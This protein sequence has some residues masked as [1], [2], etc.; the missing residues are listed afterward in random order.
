MLKI[1]M[2]GMTMQ[3]HTRL[4]AAV[5]TLCLALPA[6]AQSALDFIRHDRNISASNY[7]T[8]PDNL[9][10]QL[11]PPPA[12][13]RPFYISHY[14]RHGSRYMSNRKGYDIPYNMLC[15]ADSMHILTPLGRQVKQ[16][17]Y[18]IIADSE[19]RWG[20]LTGYGKKQ[21]RNIVERMSR[22]Y[23]EIFQGDAFLDAHS[24]IVTRCILS[25]GSAVLKLKSLHPLLNVTMN[26]SYRDM[27]YMNHQDPLLR[28]SMMTPA[29]SAAWKAF[30]EK[31]HGNT[32]LMEL[33]F[34]DTAYANRNIS[35]DD[36]S[37]YLIKTAFAQQNTHMRERESCL[38]ELFS[39]EDIHRFWQQEN[40]WWYI[41]YGHSLLNGGR[42]PYSQRYLVRQ[43]IH[44]TDSIL[45]LDVHGATLR[46]GHET[47]LLPLVCLLGVNGYDYETADL[48]SLESSG[49]WAGLIFPMA[50]NVQLVFY[51]SGPDDN[52]VLF[53]ILLNEQEATLPLPGNIAPYYRWSDFRKYYLEKLDRYDAS[54]R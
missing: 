5:T 26:S 53:K 50:S 22:N 18:D 13:K 28:D 47:V 10:P 52:D 34:T 19:G 2:E 32:R 38:M 20:D 44:D 12:G 16:E 40:A 42:Q 48:E 1:K 36:L 54:K 51:R 43:I 9:T 29:A 49:W 17:L 4:V 39:D 11:T 46:F 23:P 14:G 25:M 6:A 37:Y 45:H 24:T 15:H 31:R 41:S 3:W 8:Y 21:Q 33:L 27:F 35:V 30:K 7:S